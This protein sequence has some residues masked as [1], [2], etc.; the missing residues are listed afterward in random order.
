MPSTSGTQRVTDGLKF[1]DIFSLYMHAHTHLLTHLLNHT[2]TDLLTHSLTKLITYS[3]TRGVHPHV[4]LFCMK[5]G[6]MEWRKVTKPDFRGKNV[7]GQ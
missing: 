7:L 5:L 4:Y 3:F 1:S 2:L 6:S